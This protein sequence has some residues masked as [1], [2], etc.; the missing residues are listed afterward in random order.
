M[1]KND[2]MG[3]KMLD[4]FYTLF[5]YKEKAKKDQ[6]GYYPEKV[7][8]K[9][10]PERRFLWTS[11]F[12]VILSCISICLNMI[13]GSILITILPAKKMEIYPM[14]LEHS[15]NRVKRMSR[16]ETT[17]FAGDLVT[18]SL[19]AQYITERY[20]IEN[21]SDKELFLDKLKMRHGDRGF[22][23]LASAEDVLRTFVA[24]EK[25]YAEYLQQNGI[26]RQVKIQQIYPVSMDFWQVRFQ[27]IDIPPTDM[28]AEDFMEVMKI[29]ANKAVNPLKKGEPLVSNWIATVRMKFNFSKYDNKD[30]GLRN[31]YGLTVI[32]YDLSYHG[33][34]VK[35]HR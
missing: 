35:T 28:T 33:N 17:V 29:N 18:E 20:V 27:T 16:D 24:T 22:V 3:E 34:N 12:L 13:L 31:P 2:F 25:I 1:H 7:N 30:L 23:S 6:L 4:L 5:K 11:R 14:Q 15:L 26:Q 8:V 21:G 10:F 32:S 9:A 19:L